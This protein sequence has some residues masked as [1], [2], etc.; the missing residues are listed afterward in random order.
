LPDPDLF[1]Y[2]Y[3]RRE[4]V[5]LIGGRIARDTMTELIYHEYL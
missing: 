3:V 5:L 2:A 1:L 4:A